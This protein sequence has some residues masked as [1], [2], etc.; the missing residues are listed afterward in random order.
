MT[1]TTLI[2]IL[3]LVLICDVG[4]AW[5]KHQQRM[6]KFDEIEKGW[7]DVIDTANRIIEKLDK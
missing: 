2:I 5:Y 6:K 4:L 3:A 7:Q 1:I